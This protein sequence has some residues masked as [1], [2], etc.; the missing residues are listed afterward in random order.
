MTADKARP[1]TG[2]I[3]GEISKIERFS[4]D[5][6]W[7]DLVKAY[8]YPLLKRAAPELYEAA[9]IRVKPKFLDKEF[10]DV[11]KTADPKTHKSPRFVDILVDVPLKGR[12]AKCVLVHCE[13]Q[14]RGGGDLPERMNFYRCLIYAHYRREPAAIAIIADKRP[15]GESRNYSHDQYGVRAV[16]EYN[17]LVLPELGDEELIAS[18]N[19]IDIVLYAAKHAA[20]DQGG[21]PEVQLS[22]HS[23]EASRRAR[24]EHGGQTLAPAVRAEDNQPE[25]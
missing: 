6:F 5:S 17:N 25:G 14:S 13:A 16:Y 22:A 3:D 18:G 7:K 23:D 24:L 9:D 8:F 20:G 19:P 21:T 4:G 15:G 2:R 12:P 11:L 1:K 10:T